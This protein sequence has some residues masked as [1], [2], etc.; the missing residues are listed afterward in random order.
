VAS[1]LEQVEAELQRIGLLLEHDK[2]WPSATALIAGEPIAGS[3]WGHAIGHEIYSILGELEHGSGALCVKLVVGKRTYVHP[4]LYGAFFA[5][6]EV[7]RASSVASCSPLARELLAKTERQG[8]V[9]MA[10]VQALASGKDGKLAVRE[11]EERLLVYVGSEHTDTGKHEK[12]LE[13]WPACRARKA[14]RAPLP[15]AEQARDSLHIA[16]QKL[17]GKLPTPPTIALLTEA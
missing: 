6:L 10:E 16:L 7:Q 11:L 3:W 1:Q 15:T 2:L 5:L 9:R 17:Q 13:S 8:L 12:T 14:F 4:R